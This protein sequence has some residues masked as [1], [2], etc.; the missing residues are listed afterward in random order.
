MDVIIGDSA[1]NNDLNGELER[2][3]WGDTPLQLPLHEVC[4]DTMFKIRDNWREHLIALAC[5]ISCS[6]A[7]TQAEVTNYCRYLLAHQRGRV[8]KMSPGSWGLPENL[9]MPSSDAR[10][11]FIYFPTYIAVSTLVLAWQRYPELSDQL[12]DFRQQLRQGM[13]FM[14]GR[15]LRGSGYDADR[16]LVEVIE[17]LALGKVFDFVKQQPTFFPE[18][19][20]TCDKAL[21]YLQSYPDR[22]APEDVNWR[23][24]PYAKQQRAIRLLQGDDACKLVALPEKFQRYQQATDDWIEQLAEHVALDAYEHILESVQEE[25]VKNLEF[26]QQLYDALPASLVFPSRKLE[27]KSRSVALEKEVALPFGL[28]I[29][30]QIDIP[31]PK[32]C[33]PLEQQD[34]EEKVMTRMEHYIQYYAGDWLPKHA[35]N[36]FY[37]VIPQ[38]ITFNGRVAKASVLVYAKTK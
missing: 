11:D 1:D 23:F 8:I 5:S 2:L 37:A 6:E 20:E 33:I 25:L 19:T 14:V 30:A 18:L 35:Q 34:I 28:V 38:S 32:K 29:D 22:L 15:H 26:F 36:K 17:I 3:H 24:V 12:P 27:R 16:Q 21:M 9:G 10:V 13:K 31:E 7:P 4:V